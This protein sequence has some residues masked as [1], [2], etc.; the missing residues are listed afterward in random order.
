MKVEEAI[1][2]G[3]KLSGCGAIDKMELDKEWFDTQTD[4]RGPIREVYPIDTSVGGNVMMTAFGKGLT[5]CVVLFE[6][7]TIMAIESDGEYVDW[8]VVNEKGAGK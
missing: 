7:G 1:K 4:E 2:L 6:S 3:I 8:F 5:G